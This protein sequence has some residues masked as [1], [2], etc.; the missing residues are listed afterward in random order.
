MPD[1]I[2]NHFV[3]A[4]GSVA[5][6]DYDGLLNAPDAYSTSELLTNWTT[7]YI[8]T[9]VNVGAT[10]NTTVVSNSGFVHIIVPCNKG[11]KFV[12]TGSGGANPRAWAFTDTDYALI[13]KSAS[14]INVV[15]VE[16][17]APED[18][19]AIFNSATRVSYR[20]LKYH[21]LSL[22]ELEE[23]I[24]E[25]GEIAESNKNIL[26]EN[27][28]IT[29]WATGYITT[30]VNVGSTV[31]TTVVDNAGFVHIIV[32]CNKGDK[33]VYTGVGGN[34]PKA[35]AF[36]DTNYVLL[37]K[38]VTSDTPLSGVELYAP[39]D[40][41]AIFNS[42]TRNEHDLA[43][44]SPFD[45]NAKFSSIEEEIV[46]IGYIDSPLKKVLNYGDLFS[47]WYTGQ[48]DSY[49]DFG[50]DTTYSEFMSAWHTLSENN[51]EY[52]EETN[53]GGSSYI[54]N[55]DAVPLYLYTLKSNGDQRNKKPKVIIVA[56]EHG[57][58]KANAFG[59]Y[60]FVK[61]LAENYINSD[62]LTYL[63]AHVDFLIIP[64]ANPYG[65]DN[66]DYLN[67]NGVNINRNYSVDWVYTATGTNA[68][69]DAPFDQPE[70]QI[71]RDLVLNNLDAF[72]AIDFH[73]NGGSIVSNYEKV[74]WLLL[75]STT[76]EYYKKMFDAGYSQIAN[77][78]ARFPKEYNLVLPA[79]DDVLGM[80][81]SGYSGGLSY[82]WFISQNI[83]GML[84]EGFGGFP[85]ESVSWSGNC[86]KANAEIIG[87]W[88][89]Q[90]I[91]K[92]RD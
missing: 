59:L 39:A 91:N 72:L 15:E 56:G 28:H 34:N 78:T 27:T 17:Y 41:Y 40:G 57:F 80:L 88:I 23:S 37:E 35:W 66:D 22:S 14:E 47:G 18:G 62:V 76:D 20:L 90:V 67:A 2:V 85:S 89:A 61:D 16:L 46:E 79:N 64:F 19:Y 86:I 74:N 24:S 48:Q 42:T 75:D 51:Q 6:Y 31:N 58:E 82:K 43:K 92:Y 60:Y 25:I 54:V 45:L 68:S 50:H 1:K 12:L 10:V 32:S 71:I 63:R 87:N 30:N 38:E 33:F 5:R 83:L 29:D 53:L 49:T 36:T 4:D 70:T 9:N 11:D 55:G 81:T 44:G 52:I 77:L 21:L 7:G 84:I 13:E 26:T 73:E 3:L 65:F 8:N 69:G